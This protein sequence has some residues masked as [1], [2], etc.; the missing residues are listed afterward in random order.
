MMVLARHELEFIEYLPWPGKFQKRAL[1][2]I[3]KLEGQ[4]VHIFAIH[5]QVTRSWKQLSLRNEQIMTLL[6]HLNNVKGA[7]LLVGDFNAGTASNVLR[8]IENDLGLTSETSLLNYKRT[9]P[10]KAGVL[11]I[12]LD[13]FYHNDIVVLTDLELGPM[14]DSDH[15]P[16]CSKLSFL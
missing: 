15:R 8:K 11:G 4:S 2:V 9:W 5:F 1:H 6:K 12:Q 7:I 13:H 10:S 14:L 3:C 16:I